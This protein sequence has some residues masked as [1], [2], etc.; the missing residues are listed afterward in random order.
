MAAANT[1]NIQLVHRHFSSVKCV[2]PLNAANIFNVLHFFMEFVNK[3][4]GLRLYI[5]KRKVKMNQFA[6]FGLLHKFRM[7][8]IILVFG[9]AP[10]ILSQ[11][12]STS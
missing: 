9:K 6:V 7:I 11:H 12:Y 2:D 3:A 5:T 1:L 8:V 4:T 10:D